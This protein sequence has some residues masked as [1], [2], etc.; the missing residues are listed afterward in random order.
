MYLPTN[1][2]TAIVVHHD[3][4]ISSSAVFVCRPFVSPSV[5][6][7]KSTTFFFETVFLQSVELSVHSPGCPFDYQFGIAVNIRQSVL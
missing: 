4:E 3:L 5:H 1:S 2:A 6:L 7:I